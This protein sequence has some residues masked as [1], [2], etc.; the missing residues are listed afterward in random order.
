MARA[1]EEKVPPERPRV[2]FQTPMPARSASPVNEDSQ[3]DKDFQ[4]VLVSSLGEMV[5]PRC[6]TIMFILHVRLLFSVLLLLR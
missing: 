2:A 6:F 5:A 4:R 1:F 3:S